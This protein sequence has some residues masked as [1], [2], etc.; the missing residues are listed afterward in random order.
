MQFLS[1]FTRHLG[2][3]V[4]ALMGVVYLLSPAWA[5]A[6]EITLAC[7][8]PDD[9]FTF[10]LEIDEARRVVNANGKPATNVFIDRTSIVFDLEMDDGVWPHVLSRLTGKLVAQNPQGGGWTS[11]YT[12]EKATPK[13]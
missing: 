2:L 10:H 1:R 13:F 11:P 3:L 4:P 7:V 8:D 6:Q 9:G 12:C 5:G